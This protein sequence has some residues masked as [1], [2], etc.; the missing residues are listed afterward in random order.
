M[1][2]HIAGGF[3][4]D[5]HAQLLTRLFAEVNLPHLVSER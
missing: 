5:K 1:E 3:H 4:P 2:G